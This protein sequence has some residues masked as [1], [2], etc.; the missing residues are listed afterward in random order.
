MG[1]GCSDCRY[2]GYRGRVPVFELLVLNEPVREAILARKPSFE[3][4]RIS[5]E[6]TGL[7]TLL[8]D[9][10]VKASRGVTS[11]S[12]VLRCLPRLDPPRPLQELRRLLGD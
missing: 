3:I 10:V 2:T 5:T 9:G 12:E 6:S 8:E 11:I 4:R 7:V 1:G